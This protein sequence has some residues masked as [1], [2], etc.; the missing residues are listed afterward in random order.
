M[1]LLEG[2]YLGLVLDPPQKLFCCPSARCQELFPSRRDPVDFAAPATF[3]L[4]YSLQVTLLFHR[5]QEGVKCSGTQVDF[6][7]VTDLEVYL[8]SPT[9]LALEES[10]D[11]KVKMVLY[12]SLSPGLIQIFI[13]AAPGLE[14]TKPNNCP[15]TLSR[16][17]SN[18]QR[19]ACP[20][21]F[22]GL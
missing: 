16:F 10:E 1:F 6:E 8:V 3:R 12:Q 4:P 14:P 21:V 11:D 15:L 17:L 13:Q 22:D 18:G 7:T 20:V 9:R 19:P 2:S 5:M